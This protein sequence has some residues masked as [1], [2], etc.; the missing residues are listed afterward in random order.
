M[1]SNFR[2]L[3]VYRIQSE[4]PESEEAL[5]D[6]L[7]AAEFKPCGAFAER[8]GGFE[9]P[10]DNSGDLMCRRLAGNDLIQ[11]RVQ[12]RVLPAAA[13]KEAL[14]ERVE[15]FKQR[16]HSEP[17]RAEKRELKEEIYSQLL[18]QALTRSDRV[19]AFYLRDKKLLVVGT[20]SQ[21]VAEYLLDNLGR[22]L[23][24]LR[25]SPL[26]FKQPALDL[27]TQVFLQTRVD[28]F[29]LGRECR[30]RDPSDSAATVNWLDID[31]ADPSV[32]RHVTEGLA[33]DRLGL[34]FDQVFRFVL[35]SDLVVR[36]L[37]LA[38]QESI[39]DEPMDDPLAK[40]DADFVMLSACV[41]QLMEGLEKS[42]GGYPG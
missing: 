4:W 1:N 33:V 23:I 21:S 15:E 41:N 10:V 2:N 14:A 25:Y 42:L 9:T 40:H 3:R 22:A 7:A 24:S 32:R 27:L 39:P 20:A 29:S 12:S 37:R 31:L 36:K 34:N 13:V 17:N 26:A 38:D 8:S 30:M 11:L 6:L 18:P 5:S 19:Q 35:D 16:M 28:S